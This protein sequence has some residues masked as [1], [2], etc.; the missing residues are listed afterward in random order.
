VLAAGTLFMILE[1]IDY[2]LHYMQLF[3]EGYRPAFRNIHN[4]GDTTDRIKIAGNI[5]MFGIFV[6]LPV[7]ARFVKDARLRYVAPPLQALLCVVGL[8]AAVNI[9]IAL[10]RAGLPHNYALKNN[11]S[12]FQEIF[13][14]FLWFAWLRELVRERTSPGNWFRR[15]AG[16]IGTQETMSE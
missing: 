12:E 5:L 7:L 4:T 6:V 11:L 2:G 13:V 10:E 9:A 8:I 16:R 3:G 15:G 1:E 14:Y